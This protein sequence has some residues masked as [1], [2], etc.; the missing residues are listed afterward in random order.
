MRRR[1]LA[2]PVLALALTGCVP[3]TPTAPVPVPPAT[4]VP[5]RS[6]TDLFGPDDIVAPEVIAEATFQPSGTT[7]VTYDPGL[8]PP[9]ATARL[10]SFPGPGGIAVRL[11]VSG[12]VPRHMYGA[13][14]HTLP[15]T[16][17]PDGSG[18]HYRHQADP[19]PSAS[20]P[21]VDPSYANP[22]NEIWLDF[23]ADA[24]GRATVT[25]VQ[26]QPFDAT[27]PPRSLVV[28][29]ERTRTAA[30]AAGSAGARVGCLTLDP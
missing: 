3:T 28:H 22:R 1:L 13:H 5:D 14:L 6:E 15:C 24:H 26:E 10:S 17:A 18:P 12:M 7:A 21:S 9:G 23:T 29:A 2:L 19:N 4:P 25:S 27:S 16:A 30:G 20:A 8:V 11:S